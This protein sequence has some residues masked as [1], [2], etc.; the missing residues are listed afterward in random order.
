MKTAVFTIASRNYFA[1]V[2]TLMDSLEQTNG[3][4]DRYVVVADQISAD[5]RQLPRNFHL[6]SLEELKLP[7]RKKMIF[8]YSIM[9]FNTAVK[10]YAFTLLLETR[11]YDRVVYM[12]PDIYVY[13]PM[14][15]VEEALGC[16]A[17]FVL[18]PH[19]TGMWNEDGKQPDEPAIMRSGVY[20]LGF[21]ALNNSADAR[22][23]VH[24]WE[25]KLEYQCIVDIENGIFVDQKWIDLVPGR[26][27]HVF[28]LRHNGYNTAYWNLSH[29]KI[30]E[31]N[32]KY[33]CNGQPLVFFHYSGFHP[34]KKNKVSKHSD[35][36]TMDNIGE[37][38]ALFEAYA[39]KV[40]KNDFQKWE[41]YHYAYAAFEDG[42]KILD[43]FRIAY[44][45][46]R[47][48][49]DMC[50]FDPFDHSEIFY[51]L[52]RQDMIEFILKYVWESR[53]DL[54]YAFPSGL[55]DDYINWF[56]RCAEEDYGIPRE[57][58]EDASINQKKQ[59]E[60]SAGFKFRVKNKLFET[61]PRPVWQIGRD[62]YRTIR[63][64]QDAGNINTVQE[65]GTG[66][67]EVSNERAKSIVELKDGVNLVGYVRSEHGIGETCR[68]TAR[69]LEYSGVRWQA[70]D[71]EI[72]N[73][74]RQND[75]TWDKNI[76]DKIEYKVSVFC[77]NADQMYI[78]K[79][80]T[81]KE[82]WAGYK[83]GIWFW[84][85][86]EFP[87][88]WCGAFKLVDEIWAP[89]HFIEEA[90]SKKAT[91]PVV[92]MPI[93]IAYEEDKQQYGRSY[94]GLPSDE[95]VFLFLNMFDSL[96]FQSRKNPKAAMDAFKKAF[97][98]DDLSAGLV[99]KMNN[100]SQ[101]SQ[102][103]RNL[104]EIRGEYKNIYFIA[105][106]FTREEVN[107]LIRTCNVAV[108]MHKSEGLGLLCQE[109]MYF[110]KPVIAT[111]WSG[112][113]DFMTEE[114]S[115]LVGYELAPIGEDVGPY[116]FWQRWAQ[117]DVE[118]A[119]AYMVRLKEDAAYYKQKADSAYRT[120]REEY[121]P[122][123]CGLR[124]KKRIETILKEEIS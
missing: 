23:M 77:I 18:T 2:R 82:A 73:C 72:G 9:E 116:Q 25:K 7:D 14:Q 33:F 47:S 42:R 20:N 48:L 64:R 66:M 84:E 40:L 65:I 11:G 92:Y 89:T 53:T 88:Q 54:Q 124:M 68:M 80:N 75:H 29:R 101:D 22:E 39:E 117:A 55:S 58:L 119:A 43:L 34:Q 103:M 97:S 32:G 83:I 60:H 21:L 98:P 122:A 45:R 110:G 1:F 5:F 50:G 17:D 16:G 114:N 87:D 105:E 95:D 36:F 94:F 52:H 93:G 28:I 8:R 70:Y 37:A 41:K 4:W 85:L 79:E 26:Y 12:D 3:S 44:R 69:C 30:T 99:I 35:R 112:N 102:E 118:E 123:V 27:D 91:C 15:E 62:I 81:P 31:S 78:A 104:T 96:S 63:P 90:L 51:E 38:K 113:T 59:E 46:N 71:Y 86:M 24:W 10:P 6:I 67:I 109:A 19:L 100:Q 74:S 120:I 121:S 13:E 56:K 57:Y 107:G 115:C 61:L 49:Q 111:N 106:T 108:S 76:S